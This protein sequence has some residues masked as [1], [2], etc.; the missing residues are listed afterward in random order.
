MTWSMADNMRKGIS[1]EVFPLSPWR[2]GAYSRVMRHLLT[3]HI[4]DIWHH[5]SW[6]GLSLRFP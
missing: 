5:I 2:L 6:P 1:E 3:S 4:Y